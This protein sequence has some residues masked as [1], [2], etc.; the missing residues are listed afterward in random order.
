MRGLTT[1]LAAA[2]LLGAC[3][4]TSATPVA[5]GERLY[6]S[7]L[8]PG[9]EPLVGTRASGADVSGEGA[10]CVSCHRRSGLG[11]VEGSIVIPP[12]IAKYL[13]RSRVANVEDLSLP[14]VPGFTPNAWAYTDATLAQAIRT[15]V[16]PDG[17]AL[18]PL[19]PRYALDDPAMAG[20]IA[21]LKSLTSAPVPGVS[22]TTLDFATI[23]TPD[24]DPVEKQAMLEVLQRFFDLQQKVIAAETKPL[25][26]SREIMYRVTRRWRLHVWELTGPPDGWARQLD[27]RLAAEPVFAVISGLGRAEWRPVHQFCERN[28]VPCVLP[29]IDLPV[30]DEH[31][32][33]PVYYDRGVLLEADLIASRLEGAAEARPARLVEVF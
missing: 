29:N 19:M 2:L 21:Y 22:D 10:A 20:L 16:R 7:G 4:A 11:N 28:A 9:G 8:L 12:I 23:V 27:Q 15:G 13:Y 1:L 33:Y 24:A 18:N 26:S 3:A 6:R 17:R 32:F 30:V 31:D 14:H 25:R 5:D